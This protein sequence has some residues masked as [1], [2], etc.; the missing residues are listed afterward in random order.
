MFL[1]RA[2]KLNPGSSEAQNA[3]GISFG[4]LSQH[5]KAV[6][7]LD[8]AIAIDP[9]N[10]E[11]HHNLG[12]ALGAMGRNEDA[13]AHFGRAVALKPAC[14]QMNYSFGSACLTLGR[15]S[16]AKS[17]L[18]KSIDLEPRPTFFLALTECTRFD[19]RNR[20]ASS[21]IHLER[22]CAALP[23]DEQLNLHFAL[24]NAYRDL[25]RHDLAFAQWSKGNLLKRKMIRYDEAGTLASVKRIA[26]AFSQDVIL[27]NAGLGDP[28]SA[29][30]FIVGMPRSGTTLIEQVIASH[31]DV[32][33]AGEIGCLGRVETRRGAPSP[34]YPEDF[35]EIGPEGLS[36]FG[37]SCVGRLKVLAP[38][39]A[40]RIT[41]KVPTNFWFLGLIH[42]ALPNA[43]IIHVRR[44][45][46]DTC[47]SCFSKLFD[48]P[49]PPF[50]YDLGELGRY[51]RAYEAIMEHWR[52]VLPQG[53]ML[54]VT[55][56]DVVA[57]FETEARR[58]ISYCEL[59]WN[60]AC[61]AFDKNRRYVA[62][63][64][65]VQVRRPVYR[66]SVEAW[67]PYREFLGPLFEALQS[68]PPA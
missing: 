64:S 13:V 52:R 23:V 66:T 55:Y 67:K 61:L 25:N 43:R 4:S 34:C 46:V 62:T 65:S 22:N 12:C 49:P 30:V 57:N 31:P 68:V 38:E 32:H 8:R 24:G 33:G 47:V 19:T 41:D 56:E 5:Q 17:A 2:I 37:S 36:T 26:S 40:K 20:Y 44:N 29:P 15:L 7:H 27:R 10:A 42:L 28:S 11:A 51:F 60:P 21:L 16:E 48:N 59:D 9:E 1:E 18:E 63:A 45:P 6:F 35:A 53:A 39:S 58:I 54:E 14:A 50:A 3:L